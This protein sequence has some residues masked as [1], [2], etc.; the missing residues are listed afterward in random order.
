MVLHR[1]LLQYI[2][3]CPA[4]ER[5]TEQFLA[6]LATH[7]DACLRSCAPGHITGS[8]FIVDPSI[9]MTLLVH[10][11]KLRRWLQPGGHCEA[12]ETALQAATREAFEETGVRAIPF[13]P[14]KIYDIDIHEMPARPETQAHLHYDVRFLFV[15]QP[16]RT[17]VSHESHAVEWVH[18]DE[19]LRRNADESISRMIAKA[20]ALSLA[21]A[22]ALSSAKLQ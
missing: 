21:K 9:T 20:Q 15:A 6:F 2:D 8:A 17:R 18:F 3:V 10:H 22:Q 19:A 1:Q 5:T 4:E 11:R 16:G 13:E 12:G 7:K 14:G